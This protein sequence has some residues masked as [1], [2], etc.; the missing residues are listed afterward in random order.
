MPTIPHS[1]GPKLLAY[2]G[3]VLALALAL[4]GALLCRAKTRRDWL[5]AVGAMAA[6]AGWALAARAALHGVFAP[7]TGPEVLLLPAAAGTV[8]LALAVWWPGRLARWL[9]GLLALFTGWWLAHAGAGRTDF[10]RVW[11]GVAALAWVLARAVAGQGA[12]GLASTLALWGGL[13]LVNAPAGWIAAALVGA[14][15]YAGLLAAGPGAALPSALLAALVAGGELGS[16]RLLRAGLVGP[17]LACLGAVAA[18]L[19]AGGM[20]ARI[21]K[22]FGRGGPLVAAAAAAA[23]VVLCVW[24]ARRILLR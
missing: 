9:P 7:R 4:A 14:G 10:W 6:L 11:V 19:L 21:G 1:I 2:S 5:P 17:D 16:G 13:G 20:T 15:T 3:P 12:R 24:L 23:L 18:P 22:R 8:G